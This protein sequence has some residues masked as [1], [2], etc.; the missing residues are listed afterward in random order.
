VLKWYMKYRV[1]VEYDLFPRLLTTS[2][3]V[4]HFAL[5]S[6]L[7]TFLVRFSDAPIPSP[8]P[9]PLTHDLL[10]LRHARLVLR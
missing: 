9:L 5:S 1:S 2:N 3:L 7:L 4:H 6:H 8:S 10:T